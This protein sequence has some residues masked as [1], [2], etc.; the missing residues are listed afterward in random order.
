MGKARL[1]SIPAITVSNAINNNLPLTA[2]IDD[3]VNVI[4]SENSEKVVF[5]S[6]GVV[7]IHSDVD[8]VA[9]IQLRS[10]PL[11]NLGSFA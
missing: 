11:A 8:S 10:A 4:S 3:D 2:N 9:R 7:K 5:S 1:N 6:K